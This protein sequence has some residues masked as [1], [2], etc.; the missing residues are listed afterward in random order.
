[1]RTILKSGPAKTTLT[2]PLTE[3]KVKTPVTTQ[4]TLTSAGLTLEMKQQSWKVQRWAQLRCGDEA[5][6]A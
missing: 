4:A 5:R 3:K 2:L 1:L 6:S